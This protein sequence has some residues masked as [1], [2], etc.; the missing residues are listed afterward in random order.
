[1]IGI[2]TDDPLVINEI[3]DAYNWFLLFVLC[4][5]Y[6]SVSLGIPRAIGKQGMIALVAF[7]GYWIIGIPSAALLAYKFDLG[8]S[9]LQMGGALMAKK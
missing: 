7:I 4:E 6:A 5:N 3:N 8:L 9:G 1:M 2:F